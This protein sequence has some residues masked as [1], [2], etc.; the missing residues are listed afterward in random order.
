[1]LYTEKDRQILHDTWMSYKAKMRITQIEMA[2]KLGLTQLEFSDILRGSKPIE[3]QFVNEF[4]RVLNV[5][6]ILILPSLRE[7]MALGQGANLSIKNTFIFDGEITNV[8]YSGNQ[9]VVEYEHKA[10]PVQ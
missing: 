5:D 3:Q 6:P 4:C 9:L 8:T 7:Q 2:K 10:T 1:M